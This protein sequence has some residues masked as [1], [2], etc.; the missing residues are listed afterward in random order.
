L[1]LNNSKNDFVYHFRSC[2]GIALAKHVLLRCFF[3]CVETPFGQI[4]M[5]EIDGRTFCQS[6]AIGRYLARKYSRCPTTIYLCHQP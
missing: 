3:Y 2:K 4:P 5:L 6:Y 1:I